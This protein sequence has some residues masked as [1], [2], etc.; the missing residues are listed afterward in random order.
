MN[1]VLSK[2][3]EAAAEKDRIRIGA[4]KAGKKH[5]AMVAAMSPEA[6]A[7]VREDERLQI[8]SFLSDRGATV[9]APSWA[10]GSQFSV[11]FG[12]DL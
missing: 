9:H 6:R 3:E 1:K 4:I 7:K 5:V 10:S 8:A 12:T 11:M 2:D